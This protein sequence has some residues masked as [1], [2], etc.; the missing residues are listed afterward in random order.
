METGGWVM[1]SCSIGMVICLVGFCLY[2]VIT[3]DATDGADD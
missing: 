1:M 3:D 2:R